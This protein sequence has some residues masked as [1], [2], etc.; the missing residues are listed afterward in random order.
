MTPP[1][2]CDYLPIEEELV[3]YLNNS[4]S[5]SPKDDLYQ[6]GLKLAY[7]FWKRRF[8]SNINTCKYFSL[9]WPLPTPAII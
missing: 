5:H 1:H 2:F 4:E 8:F 3:L 9:L 6:E 7:W